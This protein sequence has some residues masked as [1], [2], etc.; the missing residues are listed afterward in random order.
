MLM[1]LAF[2]AATLGTAIGQEERL[3]GHQR[4]VLADETSTDVGL[5]AAMSPPRLRSGS[6]VRLLANPAVGA[7]ALANTTQPTAAEA[8]FITCDYPTCGSG[9]AVDGDGLMRML[10]QMRPSDAF[11][12]ITAVQRF[13]HAARGTAVSRSRTAHG[14]TVHGGA[15]AHGNQ[16]HARF[17]E[18]SHGSVAEIVVACRRTMEVLTYLGDVLRCPD[19]DV[20]D[21]ARPWAAEDTRQDR[22][23]Q[24][25]TT[26]PDQVRQRLNQH[27]ISTTEKYVSRHSFSRRSH[28]CESQTP[29]DES[30]TTRA[31]ES[32]R[33]N[34]AACSE[35]P[36][37]WCTSSQ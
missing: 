8:P 19:T 29:D 13:H 18:D 1:T 6:R 34:C 3:H 2:V 15:H 21:S 37:R 16:H 9:S 28:V 32:L 27:G 17:A 4:H 26:A 31:P 36:T 10:D 7:S 11:E 12:C 23:Q 33:S 14:D 35:H 25:G 20:D 24:Y 22:K 30:I 5:G